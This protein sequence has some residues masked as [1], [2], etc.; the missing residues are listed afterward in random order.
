MYE[1]GSYSILIEPV[2]DASSDTAPDFRKINVDLYSTQEI[3]LERGSREILHE[4]RSAVV[5]FAR[6]SEDKNYYLS[7]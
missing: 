1:A 4:F 7:G 6:E 2:W 3:E 5:Q